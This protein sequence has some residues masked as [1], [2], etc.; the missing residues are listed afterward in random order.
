MAEF[1]DY[2]HT[3]LSIAPGLSLSHYVDMIVGITWNKKCR[4]ENH[5]IETVRNTMASRLFPVNRDRNML[6]TEGYTKEN[7]SG[8]MKSGL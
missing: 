2:F 8:Y 6:I 1:I 3:Q 7:T 5:A 4:D